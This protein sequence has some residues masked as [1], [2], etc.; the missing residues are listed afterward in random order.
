M[1]IENKKTLEI[2]DEKAGMYL[3]TGII[4]DNAN[5]EK[6]KNKKEKLEKFIKETMEV[7]PKGKNV[8]EIGAAN[9]NNSKYIESLGYNVTAT[10]IA[11]AFLDE[12]KK[13]NLKTVKFNVL[14]DKF[15]EN[16]DAVFCWRV[17]VHFTKE[18]L[19][20]ALKRVYDA[21]N[22]GGIFIFNVMNRATHQVDEEWV[23]FDNEYHIGA[24]RYYRYF[25]EQ[26]LNEEIAKLGYKI[27][28][29]HKEGGD[30]KD[31]WLVYALMK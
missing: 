31:K 4:H 13:N 17:F 27:H 19:F 9:G 29:F 10:D 23:D 12:L 5:P 11:K 1:S 14:E 2:Y 22:P 28:H 24:L 26:E 6:A 16:Y 8:L 30:N 7:I 18:D 21:L 20:C 3:K 25:D 15:P